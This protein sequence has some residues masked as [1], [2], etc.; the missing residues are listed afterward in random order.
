MGFSP[1]KQALQLLR[2]ES[3]ARLMLALPVVARGP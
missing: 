2:R 3:A 1:S